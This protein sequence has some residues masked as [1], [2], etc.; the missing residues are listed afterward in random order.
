MG[1][2]FGGDLKKRFFQERRALIAAI[3]NDGIRSEIFHNCDVDEAS[4]VIFSILRGF[5]LSM[6]Y[7]E[8]ALFAPE[9]CAELVL[10]GLVRRD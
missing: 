7:Q 3:I 10:R 4:K 8:E 2:T 5:F 9:A 1:F 6:L